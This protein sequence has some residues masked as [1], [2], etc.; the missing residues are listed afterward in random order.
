VSTQA[1]GADASLARRATLRGPR[2]TSG[3]ARR[4][5]FCGAGLLVVVMAAALIGGFVL[6]QPNHQDLD[7][8]MAAPSLSHPFGTDDLGRDV[9]SRTL[10][11]T[12][13]DLGLALGVT[14][15]SVLIGLIVGSLAGYAGGWTERIFMR[16]VDV[17]IGFPYVVFV[18]A[19]VAIM[20]P[21]VTSLVIAIVGFN[22]ALYA[23]LARA[24]MLVLRGTP[25]VQAA[26]TLGYSHRRVVLRHALPNLLR[27]VVVYSMS[28]VVG[29][30]LL[31]ASLSF[32]GLGV[33]PPTPEWGAIIASGQSFLTVAWWISTLPGMVVALVGLAF[34]TI[35]DALG[36]LLGVRRDAAV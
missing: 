12:W 3:S 16:L 27:P 18:L 26:Q 29:V 21:G 36:E 5:L 13:L 6:P 15:V 4:M 14:A 25:F 34:V 9:L 33:R 1:A 7:V 11:A 23:R 17:V 19:V 28:D 20:G 31:I 32:L 10:A 22:W 35:G 24:E 30:I 2:A 8:T